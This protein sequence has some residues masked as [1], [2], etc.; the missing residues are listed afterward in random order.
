MKKGFTLVELLAVIVILAVLLLIVLPIVQNTIQGSQDSSRK[1]SID[2]YGRA[3][4]QAVERYQMVNHSNPRSFADIEDYIEYNG[5]GT[6]ND[7]VCSTKQINDDYT[8]YLS[9]CTVGGN[10]VEGHKYGK[11]GTPLTTYTQVYKPQYY[12]DYSFFGAVGNTSAPAVADRL[13]IPPTGKNVYLGYD[14]NEG[15]G[16][17][18]AGYVCFKRNGNEY[19]LKGYDTST[20]VFTKNTNIIKEAYKEVVDTDACSSGDDDYNCRA[21]G[22]YAYATSYGYADAR[23]DN[24]GCYVNGRGNFGC[25]EL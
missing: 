6:E 9:N 8:V 24:W 13:T 10:P 14:V 2:L 18:S 16:N 17:I 19:C 22:L 15:T 7:V 21:D 20:D 11:E 25:S 3:A 4:D 1:A 12:G 23:A 5:K